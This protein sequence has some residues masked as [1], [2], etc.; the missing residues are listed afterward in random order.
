M[1]EAGDWHREDIKA[2]IRKTGITMEALAIQ[3]GYERSSVR[4]AL[5]RPSTPVEALIARHLRTTASAIWPSR[6]DAH[7]NPLSRSKNDP[8]DRKAGSPRQSRSAA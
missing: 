7:G 4:K 6:Y 1:T 8:N 5:Y 2:A 3:H